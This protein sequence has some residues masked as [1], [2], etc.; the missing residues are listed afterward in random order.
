M[1]LSLSSPARSPFTTLSLSLCGSR[2]C[3]R[4]LSPSP[5]SALSSSLSSRAACSVEQP[6]APTVSQSVPPRHARRRAAGRTSRS[7]HAPR[8]DRPWTPHGPSS[9]PPCSSCP[10]AARCAPAAHYACARSLSLS[11]SL[12]HAALSARPFACAIDGLRA[13]ATPSMQTRFPIQHAPST[14]RAGL[15]RTMRPA[16]QSDR[17]MRPGPIGPP[18]PCAWPATMR[19]WVVPVRLQEVGCGLLLP[20]RRLKLQFLTNFHH[21]AQSSYHCAQLLSPS[22]RPGA[23]I[24][25]SAKPKRYLRAHFG[26]GRN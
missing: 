19:H 23:I 5:S 20:S 3:S 2:A 11:L 10:R 15:A 9:A 8:A 1:P 17:P 13:Y 4:A 25:F 21:C 16:N 26:A 12:R 14:Y 18:Q 24:S 7:A 6:G 22:L